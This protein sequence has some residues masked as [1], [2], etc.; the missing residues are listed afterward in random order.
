MGVN[1]LNHNDGAWRFDVG[2]KIDGGVVIW[3]GFFKWT[4]TMWARK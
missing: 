3:L 1:L 4:F 2:L